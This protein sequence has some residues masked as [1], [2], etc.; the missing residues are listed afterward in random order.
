MSVRNLRGVLLPI[1]TPFDD[2][3][4]VHA[5]AMRAN[6]NRWNT[7]GI[8]GYT[9]LGS[10]GERVHLDEREYC[11]V[12]E[13]AR[14]AVPRELAFIVGAGQQSTRGTINEVKAAADAG[15]EAVLV[16]TPHFYR[17]AI[18][19]DALIAH[20]IAVAD[21]SPVPLILYNMPALT[22]VNIEPETVARLREHHNII[23]VKDSS[24]DVEGL[25]RTVDL[26]R[27]SSLNGSSS[28]APATGSSPALSIRDGAAAGSSRRDDFV[29]LTGNGTVLYDALRAGADGAILAVGCVVPEL[30][31]EIFRAV[32][33]GENER[34]ATLQGKLTPL[35]QAVTTRFGIG[36]L[37]AALDM[38]G[39]VGGAVRA[40][41]PSPNEGARREIARLLEEARSA[42]AGHSMEAVQ[43][44]AL[45]PGRI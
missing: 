10:T 36:G 23:G 42:T 41:L 20:Y 2:K 35:A 14:A 27:E 17:S 1:V 13:S 16:I 8:V 28:N 19:Q 7:T 34:A 29:V 15:A 25:K 45:P 18:T 26:V 30:C 31:S 21:S 37:K 43:A 4:D 11:R 33:A 44:R 38:I 24:A 39:Y 40:P 9:V 12:T 5:S 32:K 3:G 22:G 6:I